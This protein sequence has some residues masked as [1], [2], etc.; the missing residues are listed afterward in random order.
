VIQ[1][2]TKKLTP[3]AFGVIAAL[4]WFALATK[5]ASAQA[6]ANAEKRPLS[7]SFGQT[8]SQDS[9]VF[10]LPSTTAV[11]AIYGNSSK[12]DIVSR[13][14]GAVGYDNIISKQQIQLRADLDLRRYNTY[15]QLN[16]NIYGLSAAW[17]GNIDRSIYGSANIGYNSTATEF[18]DQ[19]GLSNNQIKTQQLGATLGYRFTPTWSVFTRF[20]LVN[21]ENSASTLQT[22][23]IESTTFELGARF[24]PASGLSGEISARKRSVDYPNSQTVFISGVPTSFSNSFVSD[25]V[26]AKI[27]YA[28]NAISSFSGQLGATRLNFD[29]LTQRNTSGYLAN[30][31][32]N[33]RFSDAL[34]LGATLSKDV[35][36]DAVS[37]SS[38]ITV[39]RMGLD[40]SW[41]PTGRISVGASFF[42]TKRD[43]S[44]DPGVIA[45]TNL[46]TSDRIQASSVTGRYEL[47]RT[48]FL[49][50]GLTRQ[51]RSAPVASAIF[52]NTLVTIGVDFRLD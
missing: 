40:A 27:S 49:T 4:A 19:T 5:N 3:I 20:D 7:I 28:P 2:P 37:F 48:V 8:I 34:N 6:D 11:P 38:P 36:N 30:F 51:S 52:N 18:F 26:V 1:M 47:L 32:Y 25:Q 50:A 31:K 22:G 43:F 10:R 14:Y 23:N 24:E 46:L 35:A 39:T 41:R 29:Q 15:S 21:R 16:R 42:N 17:N 45:G 12:S 44:S 9:N 13:T 33:Y